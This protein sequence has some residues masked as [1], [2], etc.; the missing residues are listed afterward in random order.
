MLF[1]QNELLFCSIYPA[2]PSPLLAAQPHHSSQLP[3]LDLNLPFL[4]YAELD[5]SIPESEEAP[6]QDAKD[7]S[8]VTVHVN[9]KPRGSKSGGGGKPR[10]KSENDS[11]AKGAA[12]PAAKEEKKGEKTEKAAAPAKSQTKATIAKGGAPSPSKQTYAD[13][14]KK[15]WARGL[16]QHPSSSTPFFLFLSFQLLTNRL[17]TS[18]GPPFLFQ[19]YIR[20]TEPTLS[21]VLSFVSKAPRIGPLSPVGG[22]WVWSSACKRKKSGVFPAFIWRD[23]NFCFLRMFLL[24]LPLSSHPLT[25]KKEYFVVFLKHWFLRNSSAWSCLNGCN[26]FCPNAKGVNSWTLLKKKNLKNISDEQYYSSKKKNT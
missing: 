22:W 9:N 17:V 24:P 19:R 26:W 20:G 10:R 5:D 16:P 14:L 6:V 4:E 25:G 15:K 18:D 12:P 7:P 13:L 8:A 11:D 21:V 3:V 1:M 23:H 2:S